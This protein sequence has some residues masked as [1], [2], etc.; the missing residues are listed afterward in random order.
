ME[1]VEIRQCWAYHRD[2]MR[3]EHPAGHP[4]D[5]VVQKTWTDLQCATP[6]E[7]T[8]SAPA[9][10]MTDTSQALDIP[11]PEPM[12][13]IAPNTCVACGHKHK[14]GECKCGCYEFIG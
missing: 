4:G 5:H 11:M 6:G 10:L 7:F 3:C 8:P 1:S 14:S 12:P 9:T 2:G 13:A